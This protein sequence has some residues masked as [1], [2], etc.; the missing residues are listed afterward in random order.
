MFQQVYKE[1]SLLRDDIYEYIKH[2]TVKNHVNAY[3]NS[4]FQSNVSILFSI[5]IQCIDRKE[6]TNYC[7]ETSLQNLDTGF[8]LQILDNFKFILNDANDTSL[9][10]YLKRNN[11]I[12]ISN[13]TRNN[14]NATETFL[15]SLKQCL[16]ELKQN[17]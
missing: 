6:L 17:H 9:I 12:V 15:T 16:N 1:Y 13:I 8:K 14:Y 5:D 2:D 4:I 10:N 3:F 7:H 11:I